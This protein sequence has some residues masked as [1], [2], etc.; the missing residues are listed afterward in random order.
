[1]LSARLFSSEKKSVFSRCIYISNDKYH[2]LRLQG[3]IEGLNFPQWYI[4]P[5]DRM[6]NSVLLDDY[7]EN[8]K[9]SASRFFMP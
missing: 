7:L 1:M 8:Y 9:L 3:E 5:V 6:L 4:N 2:Q